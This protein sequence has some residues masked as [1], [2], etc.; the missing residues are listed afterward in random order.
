MASKQSGYLAMATR[1]DE[2]AD[3]EL[4]ALAA[5]GSEEA[6]A[7]LYCRRRP[8][9]YRFALH[10]T[11][12]D[13]LADDISQEVFLALIGDMD[14]YDAAKGT[15][16]A[17]LLG[18]A[19]KLLL[20]HFERGRF[21]VPFAADDADGSRR[22]PEFLVD[23]RNPDGTLSH[24]ETVSAVRHAVLSLPPRYREA[25]VLCDLEEMSYEE[26]AAAAGCAVGTI[27]SRLHRARTLLAHKLRGPEAASQPAALLKAKR[28]LA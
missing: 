3:S 21:F 18:M 26:A 24:S 28:C 23:R 7:A 25:V 1:F 5:G 12:S 13:A 17:Y 20:R 8:S 4:L 19:R 6:F 22:T 16:A 9:V 27:R 2:L 14:H 15:L 11:G 10:M